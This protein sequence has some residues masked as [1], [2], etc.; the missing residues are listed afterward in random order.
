MYVIYR[1]TNKLNGKSYIGFTSRTLEERLRE[2]KKESQR[3]ITKTHFHS[4]I[5]KYGIESFSFEMLE[6]GEDQR[7]GKDSR[8][9]HWIG[10][11]NPA[12]NKTLGGDGFLGRRNTPQQ[13]LNQSTRQTGIKRSETFK[14]DQSSRMKGKQITLGMKRTKEQNLWNSMRQKGVLKGPTNPYP[15]T[16]CVYCRKLGGINAMNRWHFENCKLK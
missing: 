9:S 5:R 1:A 7:I 3:K 13:S 4:A 10:I 12:Y 11:L 16:R 15:T 14:R 6:E 2:H 8:E